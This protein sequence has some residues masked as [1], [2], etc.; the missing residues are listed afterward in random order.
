MS[1]FSTVIKEPVPICTHIG[2]M[3]GSECVVFVL[4]DVML[5]GLDISMYSANTLKR[6]R[7][8]HIQASQT[9]YLVQV[10]TDTIIKSSLA[11]MSWVLIDKCNSSNNC[12]LCTCL[13][14][15]RVQVAV[16]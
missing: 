2:M 4:L 8:T 13:L 14:V 1:K 5:P 15:V 6:K 12:H 11:Q 7:K 16:R 9:K 10:L 3:C